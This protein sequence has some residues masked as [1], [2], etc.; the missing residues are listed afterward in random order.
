M[1]NPTELLPRTS[2]AAT[3]WVDGDTSHVRVYTQDRQGAIRESR[4]NGSSWSGGTAADGLVY[5]M[6][7]SPLA[8]LKYPNEARIH[9][10]FLGAHNIIIDLHQDEEGGGW[11]AGRLGSYKFVASPASRLAVVGKTKTDCWASLY[12]QQVDGAIGEINLT[13][14]GSKVSRPTWSKGKSFGNKPLIGTG[15][16]ASI[17]PTNGDEDVDRGVQVFYQLSDGTVTEARLDPGSEEFKPGDLK[18]TS[19]PPA[20]NLASLSYGSPENPV[21]QLSFFTKQNWIAQWGFYNGAWHGENHPG[22][23]MTSPSS[24]I[25][26]VMLK[27]SSSLRLYIQD[28]DNQIQ[29]YSW[30]KGWE[31][32]KK[33]SIV[34]TGN[35]Q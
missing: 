14:P 33:E 13:S 6:P 17:L 20:T 4:Y 29:E 15:L 22:H 7:Y 35:V 18:I 8:V 10:Y 34:P 3:S 5:A 1:S 26:V 9:V 24:G 2:I 12:Y 32:W 31:D 16:A 27:D 25:A 23:T 11:Y 30:L 19:A 28:M 21:F